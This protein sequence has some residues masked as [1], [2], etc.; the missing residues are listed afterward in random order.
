MSIKPSKVVP[1]ILSSY[2]IN[3]KWEYFAQAIAAWFHAALPTP[4]KD[5]MSLYIS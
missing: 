5:K 3:N 1:W 2:A 4:R